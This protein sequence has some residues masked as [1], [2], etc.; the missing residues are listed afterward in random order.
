M[1]KM[2]MLTPIFRRSTAA[3]S[4]IFWAK[5]CRSAL[6][7]STV[8]VPR[9][10]R[11]CPSSVRK[12]TSLILSVLMPRNRSAAPRS[13]MSSPAIFTLAT[14]STVTATP[15]FVYA[16][17]IFSGIEMMFSERY[18]TFS[19]TGMRRSAAD[20]AEP[21]GGFPA[22]LV[23][24]RVLAAVE[25][26]HHRRRHLDVVAREERHR[27]EQPEQPEQHRERDHDGG[28]L[29]PEEVHLLLHQARSLK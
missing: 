7:S 9:M 2:S 5:A 25:D 11:R 26:R 28:H 24:D 21:H 27:R 4:V 23:G 20:D 22:L 18:S 16:R 6:I 10:A 13:D 3:S 12:I 1:V 8:S 14:A 15:S 17:E 19:S 29:N